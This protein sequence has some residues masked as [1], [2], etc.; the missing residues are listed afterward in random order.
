MLLLLA[1]Q[2]QDPRLAEVCSKCGRKFDTAL[3]RGTHEGKCKA[4]GVGLA[5]ARSWPNGVSAHM[6]KRAAGML[7]QIRLA[8][9]AVVK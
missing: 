9:I 1:I 7:T 2:N 3:A 6:K 4:V 8:S 5:E